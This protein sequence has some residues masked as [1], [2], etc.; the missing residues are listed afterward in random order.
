MTSCLAS[1]GGILVLALGA[2]VLTAF[3]LQWAWNMALV[4]IFGLPPISL[5]E[6]CALELLVSIVTGALARVMKR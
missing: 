3:V 1:A 5:G 6:A 2:F 4:A